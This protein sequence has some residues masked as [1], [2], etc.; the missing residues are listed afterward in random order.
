MAL[1]QEQ[2]KVTLMALKTHTFK[3]PHHH[4]HR[5][6]ILNISGR[7]PNIFYK[8][9]KNTKII[10]PTEQKWTLVSWPTTWSLLLIFRFM[11][12]PSRFVCLELWNLDVWMW[13]W[14]SLE[15]HISTLSSNAAPVRPLSCH[16][17]SLWQTPLSFCHFHFF[18][19]YFL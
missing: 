3:H 4:C 12:W 6:E 15:V 17:P 5:Y 18:H 9:S 13:I 19:F 7:N 16:S 1:T 14:S 2:L 10:K 8:E 11:C